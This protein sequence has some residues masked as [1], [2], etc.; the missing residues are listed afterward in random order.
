[1]ISEAQG[2]EQFP[3]RGQGGSDV[4]PTDIILEHGSSRLRLSHSFRRQ[5]L[6][7]TMKRDFDEA[8]NAAEQENASGHRQ[9]DKPSK[10][11]SLLRDLPLV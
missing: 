2:I 1:M 10:G 3:K 11:P 6:Y 8:Y 5:V 7:R 4:S 9:Q